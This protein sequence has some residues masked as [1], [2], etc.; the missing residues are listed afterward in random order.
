MSRIIDSK[1]F[2]MLMATAMLFSIGVMP[3][4]K[5]QFGAIARALT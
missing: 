2:L 5:W 3:T 1:V 4:F